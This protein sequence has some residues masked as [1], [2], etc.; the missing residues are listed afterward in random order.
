MDLTK[1]TLPTQ[2]LERRSLLELYATF[3]TH[4]DL[5][6][7]ISS[8]ETPRDRMVAMVGWYMSA[9]HVSLKPKRPKKPYNPVLGEIFR[10]FYR[11]DDEAATTSPRAS[12]DGPLP[13]AKS[14]DLVFLAEQVSHQPPISAFYAEC[15][16]RQISCQAYVHTKT[17]FRGAYAVVQLVGKGKVML[18]SHNEEFH[19]NF[20]T[21]YIR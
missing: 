8:F 19:C 6:L 21:V 9:Y 20:P 10:C 5:F 1:I 2:I 7:N 13:W 4:A 18:H 14:S 3:F 11:V 12:R 15:P 16:T 17:Q